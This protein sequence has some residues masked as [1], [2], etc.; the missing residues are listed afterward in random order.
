MKR[1]RRTIFHILAGLSLALCLASGV[2]WASRLLSR[3]WQINFSFSP[4]SNPQESLTISNG[5]NFVYIEHIWWN[6][7]NVRMIKFDSHLA[8]SIET[9]RTIIKF[10]AKGGH[11]AIY[12]RYEIGFGY[13]PLVFAILPM[14]LWL[15]PIVGRVRAHFNPPVGICRGCGYDLRATP[16]RCPECGMIPPEKEAISN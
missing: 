1:F 10:A 9:I 3:P 8:F 13:F 11:T 16:N 6:D 15:P 14:I 2:T 12:R 5:Y 7:Q 4:V